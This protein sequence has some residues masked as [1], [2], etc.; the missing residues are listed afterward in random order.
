LRI[1]TYTHPAR[2]AVDFW[3]ATPTTLRWPDTTRAQAEA[4]QRAAD[5]GH[6]PWRCTAASV[7]AAYASAVL[8]WQGATVQRIAAQVYQVGTATRDATAILTVD[9]PVR[10]G[11]PC[12][13]WDVTGV[14]R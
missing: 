3:Y 13:V 6:Q 10:R 12:D 2:L 14:A 11:S 9:R 4:A 5:A 7:V 8:H 1:T